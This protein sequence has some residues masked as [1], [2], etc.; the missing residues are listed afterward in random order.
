MTWLGWSA[1]LFFLGLLLFGFWPKLKR[2]SLVYR[3]REDK[4]AA[5]SEHAALAL[6]PVHVGVTREQVEELR[7]LGIIRSSSV[8]DRSI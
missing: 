1:I 6:A 8:V 4:S 2:W 7:R 3:E 5:A